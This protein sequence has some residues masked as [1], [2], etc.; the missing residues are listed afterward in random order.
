MAF[1]PSLALDRKPLLYRRNAVKIWQALASSPNRWQRESRAATKGRERAEKS[2]P[3][4]TQTPRCSLQRSAPC[5]GLAASSGTSPSHLE[6]ANTEDAG[7]HIST[8]QIIHR[9][10]SQRTPSGNPL[11]ALRTSP[12]WHHLRKRR[13]PPRPRPEPLREEFPR[14]RRRC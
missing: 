5:P 13:C 2:E 1:S 10:T 9:D 8:S 12:K 6:S 4:S 3:I 11:P 14:H 7:I